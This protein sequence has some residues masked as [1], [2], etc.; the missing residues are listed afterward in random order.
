M[1]IVAASCDITSP[2]EVRKAIEAEFFST[3]TRRLAVLISMCPGSSVTR[4]A[5]DQLPASRTTAHD[6]WVEKF[7]SGAMRTRM[8]VSV[9][10]VTRIRAFP[11]ASSTPLL[12]L[13]TF[14]IGGNGRQAAQAG[15]KQM[16]QKRADRVNCF[17]QVFF[18]PLLH[19]LSSL[20]QHPSD[21]QF[22]APPQIQSNRMASS[23][24][25][26]HGD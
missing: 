26:M 23:C 15:A 21:C 24:A 4:A 10:A 8:M 7:P 20:W 3:R 14:A 17:R 12:S 16:A 5:A 11:A 9:S 19:R 2:A 25:G 6:S 18:I 22:G 13:V 1:G